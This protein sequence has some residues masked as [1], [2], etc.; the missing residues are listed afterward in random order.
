MAITGLVFLFDCR[1]VIVVEGCVGDSSDRLP[2]AHF[3]EYLQNVITRNFACDILRHAQ[4]FIFTKEENQKKRPYPHPPLTLIT[5]LT[6]L[7]TLPLF[8]LSQQLTA[9]LMSLQSRPTYPARAHH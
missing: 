7:L 8:L 2:S 5:P 6:P 1:F 4:L 9:Q 3:H